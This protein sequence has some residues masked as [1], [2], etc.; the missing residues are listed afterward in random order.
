MSGRV[1]EYRGPRDGEV[2]AWL[3]RRV[4]KLKRERADE[5]RFNPSPCCG[6]D[7]KAH[8]S[9]SINATSGLWKCHACGKKG[10]WFTLTRVFGDPLPE[11]D[12]F[13]EGAPELDVP[14]FV[15]KLAEARKTAPTPLSAGK[16]PE[17]LGYAH[18]RGI[19]NATLDAFRVTSYGENC[20]RF[21]IYA[22]G[23][24]GW[25][26]V[27]GKIKR[28]LGEMNGAKSWFEVSGGPTGLLVGQHLIHARHGERLLIVEGEMD[29]MAG[30]EIGLRNIVSL[31][32]GA[33][34][35]Q[36]SSLLRYIPED[37]PIWI[38]VDMDEAGDRCAELF[39]AQLGCE[40]VSRLVLPTKDLNEWLMKEPDLKPETVLAT[41]T[42]QE[43]EK[44]PEPAVP[45]GKFLKVGSAA[46][47]GGGGNKVIS[48]LPWPRLT[49]ALAGGLRTSQTTGLLAPSGVGKTTFSN[50]I[51][52]HA[53]RQ[54]IVVGLISLESDREEV[55]E[56]ISQA[57]KGYTGFD[58]S[59]EEFNGV[60]EKIL[61]SQLEGSAVAWE[62]C[63]EEF[64]SMISC[65]AK[66]LILD[67]LD[68]IM[69][70]AN[71]NAE[72]VK[73]QAYSALIEQAKEF[74][75]HTI[76]VWQP[77]KIDRKATV[78][79]GNQKGL[80]KALQDSDNYMNMNV[81]KS[82]RRIE[83]EKCRKMGTTQG[84]SA[85]LLRYHSAKRCLYELSEDDPELQA[86]G[87]D[88]N[89]AEL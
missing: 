60:A 15:R 56:N 7:Q 64:S 76:V 74:K 36:V 44:P 45:K 67:N 41:L 29:A 70:R 1:R 68:F 12:R 73:M 2:E 4:N 85:I 49:K 40:R 25:Q 58:F 43:S 71:T 35:V 10:N 5:L 8:P 51:S 13:K 55:D 30:Y 47:N 50:Q 80:S 83:V 86:L 69:P 88:L 66:I 26:P 39:Y 16:Y 23:A 28:C 22:W 52:V 89:F 46:K 33:Q 63:V 78:N 38:A 61:V 59:S 11:S 21:P 54:G 62:R 53:A 42:G 27:N 9:T 65:G 17:L 31:P 24:K 14:E 57:I 72:M 77:N 87:G 20:L 79:S 37:W 84:E 19:S 32:N 81:Q 6:R 3:A 34:N 48:D 75:V 82:L 18:F